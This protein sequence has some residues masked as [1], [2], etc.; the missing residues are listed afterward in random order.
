[1]N[2]TSSKNEVTVEFHPNDDAAVSLIEVR[3]HIPPNPADAETDA[4]EVCF[5]HRAVSFTFMF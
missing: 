3:F 2:A 1:M 4:V 5:V